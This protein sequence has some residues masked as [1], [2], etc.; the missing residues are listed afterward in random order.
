[1]NDNVASEETIIR[2]KLQVEPHPQSNKVSSIN[3]TFIIVTK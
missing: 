3:Y 2:L 1:M